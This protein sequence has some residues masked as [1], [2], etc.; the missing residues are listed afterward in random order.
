MAKIK[1]SESI[2]LIN[3][4]TFS[5]SK[6]CSLESLFVK[7]VFRIPDYQR[8][9]SWKND[10]LDDFW[11]DL[12]N[13]QPDRQ[14]Y[15][16]ML[17]VESVSN[18]HYKS[19][20]NEN[21]IIK[22]KGYA[23]YFI[24]DGQQ[25]ITTIIILIQNLVEYLEKNDKYLG[26][27]KQQIT[28]KYLYI[29]TANKNIVGYLF[30]YDVDDPSD[31]YLKSKIFRQDSISGSKP[32]TSYTNNLG[33][34]YKFF[35]KKN[36]ELSHEERE[37]IFRKVIKQL[38]FDIKLITKE[39]D[40]FVVFETMN[41]RGKELTNLEKLKN[42]L[43]YLSTLMPGLKN[44]EQELLRNEINTVWKFCYEHLGKNK[45]NPLDDDIFLRNHFVLYH[46]FKKEKGYPYHDIFKEIYTVK[47]VVEH[48][49]QTEYK[50]IRNYISSLHK[51]ALQWYIINNPEHAFTNG[52][53]LNEEREWLVKIERLGLRIFGP[54]TLTVYLKT[55]NANERIKYLK[56]IEAYIFLIYL[57]AGRKSNLGNAH[58]S[59]IA[60]NMYT[61]NIEW[62]L[63]KVINEIH[64]RTYG[65]QSDYC[66]YTP[67]SFIS[68]IKDHFVGS[69]GSGYYSWSGVRYFL[70]EY[71]N[72]LRGKEES[73]VKWAMPNS[74]EHIYPQ[75]PL[76][77]SWKKS[78][79]GFTPK[80]QKY[81]CN[82]LGNLVLLRHQKNSSLS[83]RPFD[84]KK[85]TVH[86][87]GSASGFFNGSHSEINVAES[88]NW[89][90][91]EIY[92]RGKK[93]LAF[94]EDNWSIELTSKQIKELLLVDENLM[95]KIR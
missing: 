50:E 7:N 61:G 57:C 48:S 85:K 72:Q 90:P 47:N 67:E 6:M 26:F 34:C 13:L 41:N 68:N 44:H 69:N 63:Y 10:E 77:I 11:Q 14:H 82:S 64:K 70:F 38:M 89:N 86:S 78:F 83:N 88:K 66:D 3:N 19:W 54:L 75:T 31:E 17:T 59:H 33:N 53:I 60:M 65:D 46:Y 79:L 62:S 55:E 22:N 16:G 56:A 87:T 52:F 71:D 81:L 4:S 12:M 1:E 28:E 39:L 27:T 5:S 76:D 94:L 35:D 58:F 73:K 84:K 15:T 21:W 25:R 23:P 95:K 92:N 30:G 36:R 74:I 29:K 40:I 37:A 51:A 8:G 32:D 45:S 91:R 43:I 18:S 2:N 20:E 49:K 24:V 9:Y 42:R 80:Q 93:M